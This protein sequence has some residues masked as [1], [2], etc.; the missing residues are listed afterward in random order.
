MQLVE[1][2]LLTVETVVS[3]SAV[4]LNAMTWL[5]DGSWWCDGSGGQ[6]VLL[7]QPPDNKMVAPPI[8]VSASMK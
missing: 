4:F 7:H 3:H 1:C 2:Y 8:I 5:C 6:G